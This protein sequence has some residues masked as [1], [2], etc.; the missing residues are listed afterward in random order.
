MKGIRL[1]LKNAFKSAGKNKSQIIGLSLLVMLVSLVVAVLAA[2]S[3]RVADAYKN[4]SITSNI[5]DIVLDVDLNNE[6][7]KDADPD[8]KWD[9]LS[10]FNLDKDLIDEKLFYQQYIMNQIALKNDLDVSF[11]E[12]RL[13][14]GLK[15]KNGNIKLKAIS[16]INHN[17]KNGVDKLVISKGRV[18]NGSEKEVVIGDSFAKE[19]NIQIGDI[20]RI[21]SDKYGEDLLVKNTKGN[22]QE[23]TDLNNSIKNKSAKEILNDA[24]YENLVWFE[25]VGIGSSVDFT[26]PLIDQ[27]TV[28]PNIKNEVLMYMDPSWMGYK[29]TEYNF[30]NKNSQDEF[31]KR[32]I[33]TYAVQSAKVVVSSETDREA[34]FSIK[35]KNQTNSQVITNLNQE[36]K[37]FINVKREVNYFYALNDPLYKFSARVSTFNT[38]MIGYNTM[39]TALIVVI[40]LIAGFTTILTTKKQ[41][42]LQSRQ[43]GCL[44]SLGY[45]KREVVNNFI[46]IPLIV[47]ILGSLLGWI[48]SI[49]IETVIVNVFSNYFNIGFYGFKFNII[50]FAL[51]IFAVWIA[52]T[53]L[54]FIIGYWTIRLPALTLLKGGDDKIINKFSIYI[55]SLSS[56]RSFSPR[57][58][59]ALLTTSL[60]KLA[61][62]SATMLLSAT[63]ISTTVI[64]PKVMKDNMTATFNGMNYE[65]MVEYTQPIANNPWSFYKTYNPNFDSES[66]GWGQYNNSSNL[67]IRDSGSGNDTTGNNSINS[68]GWAKGWTAYPLLE[69]AQSNK[70]KDKINW[71]QVIEELKNGLISPYYY[72][73]DIAEK[74][75][76]FWTEFSYLNWKNMSTKL[77]QNLDRAEIPTGIIGGIAGSTALE[78]LQGQ[79]PDYRQLINQDLKNLVNKEISENLIQYSTL[80]LRIYSKYINGLKLSYN[81]SVL[82]NDGTLNITNTKKKMNS[83]FKANKNSVSEYWHSDIKD[84]TEIMQL[85]NSDLTASFLWKNNDNW[86]DPL[87]ISQNNLKEFNEVQLKNLNTAL[88]LWFGSVLDGRLGTAILQTTYTRSP[89]FVQEYMKQAIENETNYNI[90]FNLVPYDN[91]QDEIG[92]M[93]NS[94]FKTLKNKSESAK[95]YGINQ[96]S[97]LVSLYDKNNNNIKELLFKKNDQKNTPIIINQSMYKKMNKGV[98]ETIKLD[99]LR[100]M[101]Q[102]KDNKN[103]NILDDTNGIKYGHNIT[104]SGRNSINFDDEMRTQSTYGYYTNSGLYSDNSDWKASR[105]GVGSSTIGGI[106]IAAKYANQATEPI[107]IYTSYKNGE[108]SI[109]N[110]NILDKEFEIVGIQNGYGQPQGW[111]SNNDANN[112]LEYNQVK[113][114]NFKNWF[115]REYP[116]GNPLYTFDGFKDE[117][118]KGFIKE[119]I[120]GTKNYSDFIDKVNNSD[121]NSAW[122][123]MNQLYENLFPIF[124][125]KYSPEK[126]I[127]DLSKGFSVSHKFAD[128]SSIGLN[129]NYTMIEEDC[130][131]NEN[132]FYEENNKCMVID[133]N[134]F[135][136]GYG[137]GTLSTMLPKEQTRQILGQ[138][139]D[140]VNMIM[141]MFITIA[142]IVSA[143][144]ILLT[145]S[146]IIY[147]NKQ[148]I[149]TMKTLGYSNPYVVRQIL[150]MYI[151]PILIMYVIGFIIG[152]Y[153]FVFIADFLAM[154]TAWVLPVSFSIWI[155]FGVFGIIAAIYIA[156]FA[157]GW[158]NIQKI[159]PL[160]AL[161]DKD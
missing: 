127:L 121:E 144:I 118:L 91:S 56:K 90:T 20:V 82:N 153:I 13:I 133:P 135:N 128:F 3:T 10:Y 6:I 66:Q 36:Y 44:K 49:F 61:G 134:N 156:T 41:V 83:I 104:S 155:P 97:N 8:N 18:F 119:V 40:I 1:L 124:N 29:S 55:K 136:E 72:T 19:N 111:I 12:A 131:D 42:E 64:A 5:R 58:R 87:D 85:A 103:I 31:Y 150:G 126:E 68:E 57:L 48:I 132:S 89:Y 67:L 95:I 110:D 32:T 139:T 28:M 30:R 63:M 27:T 125:Y 9:D 26:T 117:E 115:A 93:L 147:E 52:L 129:G 140:L 145:T 102:N 59:A 130:E 94:T 158:S 77:L 157:I 51:S 154:N 116:E 114:L 69:N 105:G 80:M 92:T 120:D 24:K 22:S 43:I 50:A 74:N 108:I 86:I 81:S 73:Y 98:G 37:K 101:L 35:S 96:D 76:F 14:S 109:A 34:Y 39:A 46:A 151:A 75:V 17:E 152:W 4:L 159:N 84:A 99:I 25:V 106:N 123:N 161:K 16:K 15:G 45:K 60:G 143:T 21:N 148:F 38:I 7:K 2:T 70:A 53:A 65:N 146:L 137:V 62:V 23:I 138:V 79:W 141:I 11:T 112:I 78:Q 107:D 88:T 122:R 100:E 142:V 71:E 54:A 113:E 33:S 47:S 160:E 149:A